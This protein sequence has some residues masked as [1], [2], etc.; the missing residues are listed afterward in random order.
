ML[1]KLFVKT[2]NTGSEGTHTMCDMCN[3]IKSLVEELSVSL[4]TTSISMGIYMYNVMFNS[5]MVCV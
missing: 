5:V 4:N 3:L 1:H 2:K